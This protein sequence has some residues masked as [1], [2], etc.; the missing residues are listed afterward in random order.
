MQ[1]ICASVCELVA[2][3]YSTN[4]PPLLDPAPA[5]PIT[6][7]IGDGGV[8]PTAGQSYTLTCSVSGTSVPTYQWRKD[9][10]V[11]Q[12][13]TTELLSSPLR[14]SDAGQYTCEVTVNSMTL[15]DDKNVVIMSKISKLVHCVYYSL[16]LLCPLVP[17][18]T[19]VTITSDPVSPIRPVGSDVTLTC[20]VVLSTAVSVEVDVS[21]AWTGPDG[22]ETINNAHSVIGSTTTY[23]SK[24]MINSFGRDQSGNYTCT[25]TVSSTSSFL[26]GSGSQSGTARVTVGKVD[27]Y[28][29]MHAHNI[30]INQRKYLV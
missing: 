11:I 16:S 29:Y 7:Q 14:L 23:T 19:S 12:G 15:T 22:L 25:A 10:S 9:G 21:T 26:T 4:L 1:R 3:S 8:T 20:T 17:P 5:P 28:V 13:E 18:P 24:A 27:I 2:G 6:V 30:V